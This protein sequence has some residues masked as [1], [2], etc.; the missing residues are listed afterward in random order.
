MYFGDMSKKV[1]MNNVKQSKTTCTEVRI[2]IN[3]SD[4]TNIKR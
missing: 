3:M 1:G 4:C 2:T